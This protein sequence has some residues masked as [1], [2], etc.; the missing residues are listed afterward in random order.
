[1]EL[2][3]VTYK[4]TVQTQKGSCCC[5][6][7]QGPQQACN[8]AH[9]RHGRRPLPTPRAVSVCNL[10]W[11]R[12]CGRLGQAMSIPARSHSLNKVMSK[13]PLRVQV[14]QPWGL[15]PMSL[16]GSR[17]PRNTRDQTQPPLAKAGACAVIYGGT[18][19]PEAMGLL[20]PGEGWKCRFL[21]LRGAGLQ[22]SVASGHGCLWAPGEDGRH[23]GQEAPFLRGLGLAL[24]GSRP[25]S[26]G[27]RRLRSVVYLWATPKGTNVR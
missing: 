25:A 19:S 27:G 22:Y 4:Q 9:K 26:S 7:G 18:R 1:M 15:Y 14:P 17:G 12:P 24:P 21:R 23:G 11:D 2:A 3:K 20:A 8:P 13:S 6:H 16:D 10:T 5:P